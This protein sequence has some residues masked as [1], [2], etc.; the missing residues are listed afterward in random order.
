[1]KSNADIWLYLVQSLDGNAFGDGTVLGCD[2]VGTVEE[3]GKNVSLI[4]KGDTIAALTWDGEVKGN[5]AY[6]QYTLANE[7]ISFKVLG[8]VSPEAAATVSLACRTAWLAL[9]PQNCLVIN[10]KSGKGASVLIRGGSSS[11]GLYAIQMARQHNFNVAT[12]CSPK[13]HE[14]VKSLGADHVFGY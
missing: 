5:G 4:R 11:V 9:F 12:V 1:M 14:R 6:N 2:F 3:A 10:R 8:S 13:H 7:F